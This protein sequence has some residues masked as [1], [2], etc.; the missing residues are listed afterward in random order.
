MHHGGV[1]RVDSSQTSPSD[2]DQSDDD[3]S[4]DRMH[5]PV[6]PKSVPMETVTELCY[7]SPTNGWVVLISAHACLYVCINICVY[8]C[9][10]LLI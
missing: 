6:N 10:A 7:A 5:E 8:P 1:K 2:D 9:L 4:D 3:Q